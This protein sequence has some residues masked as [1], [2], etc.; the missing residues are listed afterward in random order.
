MKG[1][2]ALKIYFAYTTQYLKTL[3][4]YRIDFIFGLIGFFLLQTCGVVFVTLIFDSIPQLEGWNFHQ[5]LFIYGLAQI[6]RG[7]DHIFTDNLWIYAYWAIS[8]G[9]MDRILLRPI[10]P[11]FQVIMERFQLDGIGEL[12]IGI[13][14]LVYAATNLA[15][16]FSVIQI[17]LLILLV[18]SGTLV[19]T[20]IKLITCSIAFWKK[21]SGPFVQVAYEFNQFCYYPISIYNKGI[22]FFL[23]FIIPFAITSYYPA[24]WLLGIEGPLKGVIMPLV[25]AFVFISLSYSVWKIGLNHYESAGN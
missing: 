7:L 14:L 8:Q 22:Q 20:S 10:N 18:I 2:Q 19:I 5:V 11:L 17:L 16:D 4:T 3:M 9:E 13:V 6:P 23:T 24:T 1:R 25:V 15:I 12:L 21:R